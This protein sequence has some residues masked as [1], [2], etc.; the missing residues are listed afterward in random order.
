MKLYELDESEYLDALSAAACRE[1][2][3][4]LKRL[5]PDVAKDNL[6]KLLVEAARHAHPDVVAYL[7]KLGARADDKSAKGSTA[8]TE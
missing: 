7:L 4:I 2:V 6:D 1:D 3:K 8:L 5:G